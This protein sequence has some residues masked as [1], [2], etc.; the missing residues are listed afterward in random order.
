[1]NPTKPDV[2]GFANEMPRALSLLQAEL[3]TA[4]PELTHTETSSVQTTVERPVGHERR[5]KQMPV[6]RHA[7]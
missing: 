3:E 1:M 2:S 4:N 7:A 6:A 5:F